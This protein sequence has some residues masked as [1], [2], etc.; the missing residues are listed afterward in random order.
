M[1]FCIVW[2]M[3]IFGAK[4]GLIDVFSAVVIYFFYYCEDSF[5]SRDRVNLVV[6]F[7]SKPKRDPTKE[8]GRTCEIKKS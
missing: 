8:H 5:H 2:R 6:C 3:L 1:M 7:T 4:P